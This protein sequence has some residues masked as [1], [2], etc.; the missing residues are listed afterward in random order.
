[1]ITTVNPMITLLSSS[2]FILTLCP[3]LSKL[4]TVSKTTLVWASSLLAGLPFPLLLCGHLPLI[5]QGSAPWSKIPPCRGALAGSPSPAFQRLRGLSVACWS[6]QCI[7]TPVFEPVLTISPCI[8][9][10]TRCFASPAPSRCLSKW[11]LL[12]D[13]LNQCLIARIIHSSLIY[14]NTPNE[15]SGGDSRVDRRKGQQNVDRGQR[16]KWRA[17]PGG[18]EQAN[19]SDLPRTLRIT[20]VSFSS[21]SWNKHPSSTAPT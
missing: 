11:R 7:G 12:G 13:R 5:H 1:M 17:G 3:S 16:R 20:Q 2:S 10:K 18:K 4:L 8:S 19:E 9:Q 14:L 15:E 6:Q 21:E